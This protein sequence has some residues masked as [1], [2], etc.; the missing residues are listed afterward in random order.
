MC[1]FQ[2]YMINTLIYNKCIILYITL[3]IILRIVDSVLMRR[4]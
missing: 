1:L 2:F 3:L 4:K